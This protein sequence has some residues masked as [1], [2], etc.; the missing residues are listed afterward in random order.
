[1]TLPQRQLQLFA[2]SLWMLLP[3][4]GFRWTVYHQALNALLTCCPHTTCEFSALTMKQRKYEH[5]VLAPAPSARG[6]HGGGACCLMN[7]KCTTARS[8][9][10]AP[11][12]LLAAAQSRR[13]RLLPVLCCWDAPAPPRA[14]ALG[15]AADWGFS[16]SSCRPPPAA[17]QIF[18]TSPRRT[19]EHTKA[20]V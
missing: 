6:Q 10:P 8:T 1:M 16:N 13:A 18:S 11:A 9:Q 2:L 3:R 12:L 17:R 19:C 5:D 7:S 15:W 4:L 20:A 14:L